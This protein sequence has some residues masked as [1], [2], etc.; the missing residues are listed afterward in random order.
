MTLA[1]V[2]QAALTGVLLVVL[3]AMI[4]YL[5]RRENR[6][7]VRRTEERD[8]RAGTERATSFGPA[9]DSSVEEEE[10]RSVTMGATPRHTAE[11]QAQG[12][13]PHATQVWEDDAA[14]YQAQDH[15]PHATQVW[16]GDAAE[17]Q[18]QDHTPHATQVWE[19]DAA[20]YQAQDHTPHA[21]QV[22]EGD[23]WSVP[24]RAR[25]EGFTPEEAKL[26]RDAGY[27]AREARRLS[28]EHKAPPPRSG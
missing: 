16:E 3:A 4:I 6:K 2:N 11:Y 20:E 24:H 17:Y 13:T 5:V 1:V 28:L 10:W 23:E 25:P 9:W 8:Q 19:G 12:H 7:S 22:W 15:T 27:T 21:T 14:E 18:A 26:W